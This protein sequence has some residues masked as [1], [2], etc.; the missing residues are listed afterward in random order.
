MNII[1][2]HLPI[3]V[4]VSF[5]TFPGG[6]VQIGPDGVAEQLWEHPIF[7]EEQVS[8]A[9]QNRMKF[10]TKFLIFYNMH[11]S[12]HFNIWQKFIVGEIQVIHLSLIFLTY[13]TYKIANII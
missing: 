8:T 7:L 9:I 3:H 12:T 10:I 1:Q 5:K 11:I 4:L 2:Y 13:F 6:Q